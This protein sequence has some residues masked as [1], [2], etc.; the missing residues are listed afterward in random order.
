MQLSATLGVTTFR[1]ASLREVMAKATP[2]RS[3]DCLAG[4][5]ATS[6]QE[7]VAARWALAD[8]PLAHFLEEVLIPYETDEVTRLIIDNHDKAAFARISGLTVGGLRDWLLSDQATPEVLTAV[9]AGLTPEMVAA[10]S[11]LMRN[12]DLIAVA[13]RCKVVTRFRNTL[14]LQGHLAVRLQP[15]HPADA[16]AGIVASL[17]D[18]LLYG[19]GD[20]VIGVNPVSDSVPDLVRLQHVL[21]DVIEK[22]KFQHKV[23]F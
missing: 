2:L 23:V 21:A 7:R 11:K 8:V 1:F 3:G 13:K 16:P 15:N 12:Q 20:A 5:A 10:V 22:L 17:I 14:G 4:V 19:V 18:G 6:A 9:A